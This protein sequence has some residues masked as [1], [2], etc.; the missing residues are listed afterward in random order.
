VKLAIHRLL[1]LVLSYLR[2]R[3][4]LLVFFAVMPALV[5]ELYLGFAQRQRLAEQTNREFLNMAKII[6]TQ[7]DWM[8]ANSRQLLEVLVRIP[9]IRSMHP[10][11]CNPLLA[12]LLKQNPLYVT[13]GVVDSNGLMTC[14][15]LP[16]D[17]PINDSDRLWFKRALETRAFVVG[18]Y[19]IS[20]TAHVPTLHFSCPFFDDLGNLRGV[21]YAGVDLKWFNQIFARVHLPEGTISTMVDAGGMILARSVDP[22]KWVGKTGVESLAIKTVIARINE[23]TVLGTGPDGIT[24]LYA[25]SPL[26]GPSGSIVGFVI[27]GISI[28]EAYADANRVMIRSL[29]L[30]AMVGAFAI[31]AAWMLSGSFVLQRSRE[32]ITTAKRLRSGDL[33]ARV[34]PNHHFGEFTE[35][36]KA[37]DEMAEAIQTLIASHK[38]YQHN[39]ENL[40]DERTVSLKERNDQLKRANEELKT[41]RLQLIHAEKMETVGRLAAGVAHEV[42]NPLQI[43]LMSIDFLSQS[44]TPEQSKSLAGVIN[45]MRTATQRADAIIKGVLD[46]SHSDDLEMQLHDING[47]LDKALLLVGHNLNK[48]HVHLD[49]NLDLEIPDIK[50]DP[51]K[52]E[53]V[54]INLF[55][56]A[57]DAMSK[58]GTLSVSTFREKLKESHHDSGTRKAGIFYAGETVAIVKIEDT[59]CG[60]APEAMHKIFDPFFTTK[61]TGKGTGLGL[62]IVKKIIDLHGGIIE[63]GNRPTGGTYSQLMFRIPERG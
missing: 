22:D 33:M 59:G 13:L 46:F 39:L 44:L 16:S 51:M 23:G 1:Q 3:L 58:G 27:L 34:K 26:K 6:A 41:A 24:R 29:L 63:L 35:V 36:A 18:E 12:N 11:L 4:I 30:T 49:L 20:R 45:G 8:I 31:V 9:E 7:Q 55:S 10:S 43:I 40:V 42:R 5:L 62:Y 53:Q 57:I 25:Y 37:I 47:L 60:I 15:A 54:L 17:V 19:A 32:L 21:V 56:N 2:V 48:N 28:E 50:M 14:S 61:S 38:Q 52:I